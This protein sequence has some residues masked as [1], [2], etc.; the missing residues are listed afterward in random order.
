MY[1]AKVRKVWSELDPLF[2]T[3]W[4]CQELYFPL[5]LVTYEMPVTSFLCTPEELQRDVR[6]QGHFGEY[7]NKRNV[8]ARISQPNAFG[9]LILAF[10]VFLWLFFRS[11]LAVCKQLLYEFQMGTPFFTQLLIA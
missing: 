6:G 9:L 5:H 4:E 3:P 2:W 8:Q 11:D 7:I 1:L 10:L